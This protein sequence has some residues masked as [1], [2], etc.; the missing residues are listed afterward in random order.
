M[1]VG[2]GIDLALEER[3]GLCINVRDLVYTDWDREMLNPVGS[4][5]QDDFF[6]EYRPAPPAPKKTIQNLVV[7]IGFN[8]VP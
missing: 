5:Y 3:T 1:S 4:E 6:P 2:G 8:F 7:S